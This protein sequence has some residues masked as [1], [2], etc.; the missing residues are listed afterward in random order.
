MM[1]LFHHNI[2]FMNYIKQNKTS[3]KGKYITT[4]LKLKSYIYIISKATICM[5]L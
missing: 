1:L 5:Y 3:D 4:G 2:R